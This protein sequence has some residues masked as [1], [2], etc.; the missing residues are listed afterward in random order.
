MKRRHTVL[1]GAMV[2][3]IVLYGCGSAQARK[4]H[5][6][7]SRKIRKATPPV[8]RFTHPSILKADDT[9]YIFGSHM[10]AAKS[11]DL[12]KWSMFASGVDENNKLFDN[13][14]EEP[15]EAFSFVG[16]ND[17]GGYSVWAPDVVL[18]R[19]WENM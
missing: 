15:M 4:C 13:L 18:M 6:K 11:D 8:R 17:A 1:L 16:E 14:F 5:R 12:V 9:Y 10:D 3:G 19:R 2:M 7:R